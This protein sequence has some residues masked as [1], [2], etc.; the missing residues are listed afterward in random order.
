MTDLFPTVLGCPLDSY[1]RDQIVE[2][3]ERYLTGQ[4]I[5]ECIRKVYSTLHVELYYMPDWD[6]CAL[7]APHVPEFWILRT[8]GYLLMPESYQ[9]YFI[10]YLTI[11]N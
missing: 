3:R 6:E 10:R 5:A 1:A 9:G 4:P 8:F 2:C 7:V 11:P